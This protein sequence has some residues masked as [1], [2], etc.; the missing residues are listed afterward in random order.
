MGNYIGEITALIA[1]LSFSFN[2]TFITFAG[3]KL[4]ALLAMASS[5]FIAWVLFLGLHWLALGEALPLSAE[6]MRW[7]MMGISGVMSYWI[8]S[9]FIVRAFTY[10]GPRLTL[11]IISLSPVLSALLAWFL[12]GQ[13]LAPNSTIGITMIIFGIVWVVSERDQ[14]TAIVDADY[15]K[16]VWMSIWGALTQAIS[17]VFSGVGVVGDFPALSASMMRLTVSLVAIWGF[18]IVQ[19][20][21]RRYLNLMNDNRQAVKQAGYSAI[22]GPIIGSSLMM[23]SLQHVSVGVTSTLA[24]TSPLMLLP[25][26]YFIF[27]ERITVRTIIGT[28]IAVA[29]IAILFT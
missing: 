24:N 3:R 16:G 10:I 23:V 14:K 5:L 8:S 28:G 25:I 17:F 20:Y 1:A 4:G 19:G 27:K 29:G 13:S 21:F 26:G 6:P 22:T 18:I 9:Y 11:L 12:L 7:L 2:S 15:R